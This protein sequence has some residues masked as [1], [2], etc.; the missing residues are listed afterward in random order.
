M[1][2]KYHIFLSVFSVL[3]SCKREQTIQVDTIYHTWEAKTFISVES[4]AYPKNENTP[5][6][7]TFKKDGTYSLKLDINSCGGRY[8]V[9]NSHQIE[10]GFP[11]CTEACCD[12]QFSNKLATTLA[13][14]NS[15]NIKDHTL[16]LNVP[17]WGDI[18]FELVE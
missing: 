5:I 10:I 16:K 6:L 11:A 12:S 1:K 3:I 4:I 13:K 9:D 17:E 8:H 2:A 15:F 7:L 18:K 14:V